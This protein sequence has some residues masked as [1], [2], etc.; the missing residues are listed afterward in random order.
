MDRNA[1][2]VNSS[3]Q[4]CPLYIIAP[5]DHGAKSKAPLLAKRREK[6]GTLFLALV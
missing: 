2:E 6:W 5:H 1:Q 3:G 4:E